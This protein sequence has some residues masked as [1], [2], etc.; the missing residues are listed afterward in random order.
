MTAGGSVSLDCSQKKGAA[1]VLAHSASRED[2]DKPLKLR[3]Y[4]LAHY[5]EWLAFARK[6]EGEEFRLENL[7]LVTGCDHAP[8]WGITTFRDRKIGSSVKLKCDA[9]G[10][11]TANVNSSMLLWCCSGRTKQVPC[12]D[13][14]PD[15]GRKKKHPA[16]QC[17][18]LRSFRIRSN[19]VE[20]I[21][22]R[23]R[24]GGGRAMGGSGKPVR[25]NDTVRP[26]YLPH[27]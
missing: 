27:F 1:L 14:P 11:L 17:V 24:G 6:E 23:L 9:A 16:N 26:D 22:K 25:D 3:S 15:F 5:K 21:A 7:L 13:G 12:R 19:I 4:M 2:A 20:R 18:F 10:V 8:Q